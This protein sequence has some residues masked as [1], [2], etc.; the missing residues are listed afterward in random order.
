MW[1]RGTGKGNTPQLLGVLTA[2]RPTGPF[3]WVR[4]H[5]SMDPFHTVAKGIANYPPGYQYADATIWQHPNTGR[6]YVYW[7][8]RVNPSNTGFRAMELTDDCLDVNRASDT[9]LFRT[10]NREAPAIF[11]HSNTIYLWTSGTWGWSPCQP[12]LY[13]ASHP[14]GPFNTSLNHTWH[15]YSKPK[16]FNASTL[17]YDVRDGF[18]ADGDDWIPPRNSTLPQAE[19]LCASSPK[20]QGFNFVAYDQRPPS[21][22]LLHVSYKTTSK[23]FDPD[24]A[25][26][27]QPPPIPDP[28]FAGN[29][30][31]DGQPG[32]W[33]FGSQSTYI[34]PNPAFKEGSRLAQ[35]VYIADRWTPSDKTSFGTYVWLPLFVEKGRVRVVWHAAW[36]L[37][38]VT[39]PFG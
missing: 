29:R 16:G 13:N 28:G 32:I 31:E 11:M 7:R 8:T 12:F 21:S 1:V 39:S 26:G 5:G 25:F 37:D 10:P 22:Q 33:A 23:R 36:R 14:L 3:T 6:A 15:T 18:L 38:N 2:P 35:F 24:D 34:L 9:Q 20:C 4:K 30:K 27:L 19:S 17:N